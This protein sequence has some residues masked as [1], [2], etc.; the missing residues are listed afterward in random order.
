VYIKNKR[1]VSMVGI[2]INDKHQPFTDLILSGTKTIETRKSPSL[3]AYIG[4]RVGVIR[5][6]KGKAT[7]V[8]F[9]TIGE[10][11]YYKTEEQFRKDEAKHYVMKGSKY[12][13]DNEGKWG[14]PI[15]N[16]VRVDPQYI[17][18]KGIIARQI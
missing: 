3:N 9:I 5:T 7:L 16:P 6:G 1:G 10:P 14:Y 4:K 2:N 13:I 15:L 11:I 8:G 18:S 17:N 12:D